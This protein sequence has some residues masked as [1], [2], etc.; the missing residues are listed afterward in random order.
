MSTHNFIQLAS[1]HNL[2]PIAETHIKLVS[3]PKVIL[4]VATRDPASSSTNVSK[5]FLICFRVV[6][7]P[8]IDKSHRPSDRC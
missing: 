4:A 8:L 3:I 7:I 1:L 2:P 6:F 5:D